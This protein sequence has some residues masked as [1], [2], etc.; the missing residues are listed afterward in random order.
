MGKGTSWK[1]SFACSGAGTVLTLPA[2]QNTLNT[3]VM[4]GMAGQ[5]GDPDR[6]CIKAVGCSST[7]N[8]KCVCSLHHGCDMA[9]S[10]TGTQSCVQKPA[11]SPNK[12]CPAGSSTTSDASSVKRTMVL[13]SFL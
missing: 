11:I 3:C 4:M 6:M 8:S 7:S 10:T 12:A 5:A 9:S 13:A 1:E 2:V